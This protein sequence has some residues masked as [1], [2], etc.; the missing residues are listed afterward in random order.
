LI[1]QGGANDGT[2]S[3]TTVGSGHDVTVTMDD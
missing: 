1:T 2:T 3:I